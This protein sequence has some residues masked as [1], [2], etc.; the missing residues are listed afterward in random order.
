MRRSHSADYGSRSRPD[1]ATTRKTKSRITILSDL[2]C[3][4]LNAVVYVRNRVL[5]N[6]PERST[7]H[8]RQLGASQTFGK[9]SRFCVVDYNHDYVAT[10]FAVSDQHSNNVLCCLDCVLWNGH[11]LEKISVQVASRYYVLTTIQV[12]FKIGKLKKK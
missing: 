11:D 2:Q 5:G 1:S 7:K 4:F 10:D 6:G 3:H 8:S 12:I 9:R